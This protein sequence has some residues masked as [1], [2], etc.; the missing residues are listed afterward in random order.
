MHFDKL[1][2]KGTIKFPNENRPL[3]R[4]RFVDLPKTGQAAWRSPSAFA[5]I[6]CGAS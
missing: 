6:V 4:G 1:S 2:A 3:H 5:S